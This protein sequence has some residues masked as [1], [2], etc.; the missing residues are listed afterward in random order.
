[1]I[2]R[3]KNW[4]LVKFC[5]YVCISDLVA[6]KVHLSTPVMKSYV[7]KPEMIVGSATPKEKEKSIAR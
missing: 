5:G 1:M 7:C 6:I 3:L 4:V 2:R